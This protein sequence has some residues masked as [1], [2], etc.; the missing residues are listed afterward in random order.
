MLTILYAPFRLA[1]AREFVDAKG[2]HLCQKRQNGKLCGRRKYGLELY[3]F[4]ERYCSIEC[5]NLRHKKTHPK[6]K[7]NRLDY[8]GTCVG[9]EDEMPEK[10][11]GDLGVDRERLRHLYQQLLSYADEA[12]EGKAE[13]P[14]FPIT[15]FAPAMVVASFLK[16]GKAVTFSRHFLNLD[17]EQKKTVLQ[18][19]MAATK[20]TSM[21]VFQNGIFSS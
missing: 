18:H 13:K 12:I 9:H 20:L 16:A 17:L 15:Q 19:A 1:Q 10:P 5:A 6:D 11:S 21:S 8:V 2:L 4:R 3:T 7:K 14:V